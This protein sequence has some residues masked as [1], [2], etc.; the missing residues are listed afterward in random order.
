MD[1]IVFII[2]VA[3]RERLEESKNELDVSYRFVACCTHFCFTTPIFASARVPCVTTLYLLQSLLSDDQISGCPVLVLGNKIDK[4]GACSEDDI[5]SYFGLHQ[6]L[7]GQVRHQYL[8]V[9]WG[10]RVALSQCRGV[11]D[12]QSFIRDGHY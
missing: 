7:T 4:Q 12:G 1:A 5:K 10:M 3:D 6:Q 8:S 11:L 9:T 2:D